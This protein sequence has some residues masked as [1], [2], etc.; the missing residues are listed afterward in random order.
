M[1]EIFCLNSFLLNLKLHENSDKECNNDNVSKSKLLHVAYT[2]LMIEISPASSD[3]ILREMAESSLKIDP[4]NA[5]PF[6]VLVHRLGAKTLF[7]PKNP[8]DEPM[9]VAM[10]ARIPEIDP[11]SPYASYLFSIVI[12][13]LHKARTSHKNIVYAVRL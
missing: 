11:T 2:T 6:I 8:F 9:A 12:F 5:N 7:D 4:H 1:R 10:G 3:N 13:L